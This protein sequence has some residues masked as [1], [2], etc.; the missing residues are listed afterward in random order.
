MK[1]SPQCHASTIV[2]VLQYLHDGT[3]VPARWYSSTDYAVPKSVLESINWMNGAR[4][5]K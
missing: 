2:L 4:E 3:P 1:K 5:T